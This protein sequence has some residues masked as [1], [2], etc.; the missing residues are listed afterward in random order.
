MALP[1][2]SL[3]LLL[4]PPPLLVLGPALRVPLRFLRCHCCFADV[5]AR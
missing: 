5:V 1:S 3:W 4:L 2:L